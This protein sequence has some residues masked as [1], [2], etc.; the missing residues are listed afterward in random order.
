MAIAAPAAALPV[1]VAF[2]VLVCLADAWLEARVTLTGFLLC[3]PLG[4]AAV[5]RPG[6]VTVVG[7]LA[8]ALA[9]VSGLW[10]DYF[11]SADHIVRMTVVGVGGALAVLAS[12]A[13]E[14]AEVARLEAEAAHREAEAAREQSEAARLEAA[15]LVAERD[16]TRERLDRTL[17]ALAEAVTVHDQRGKTVYANA[18]AARLLGRSVPEILAAEPGELADRFAMTHEDGTPVRLS[19]LPGR[20]LAAGEDATPLLTRS[21][22]KETGQAYWLLTKATATHDSTGELLLVNVIEDVTDAKDAEMRAGFLNTASELLASSLDYEQTLQRVARLAVPRLADWC[23]VEVV[24]DH[25]VGHLVAVAHVDP[26]KVALAYRLRERY[27]TDPDEA[28]GVPA[29]LRSGKPELYPSIS[30]EMLVATARDEEHLE[31]ARALQIRS[32]MVVP[33]KVG[34][35][36]IGAVTFVAAELV[37]AYDENDLAFAEEVARRAATAVENARL[38]TER[39]EIAHMLQQSLLPHQLPEVEGWKTAALYRPGDVSSEVGGDFYD[40]FRT[41]EGVVVVL[42]DVTGKG[43]AAA[44]LTSLARHT[45][46]TAALMG[47]APREVLSLLNRVLREEPD[48]SL[49]TVVCAQFQLTG[50]AARMTSA[51]AGHPLPLRCRSGAPPGPLGVPGVLLGAVDDGDWEQTDHDLPVGDTILFYT[52]GVPDTP[53][54]DGRFDEEGLIA[55]LTGAPTEPECL[56]TAVD[57]ARR[58]FQS[59]TVV[60]DTAMLAIQ[61]VGVA[62]HRDGDGGGSRP[63]AFPRAT[64]P[65]R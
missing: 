29:V 59:G 50:T 36:V 62:G 20:R 54:V 1:A 52:D 13:R 65:P 23:G 24:D 28:T 55:A 11:L 2:L 44:A 22:V 41:R 47:M 33:M 43:V 51:S 26:E 27:P 6:R 40:L 34:D 30:D 49:V 53:G 21:V 7:V 58:D 35:R 61:F 60:D 48:L 17:G 4:L 57:T 37:G 31:I 10:N 3:A 32:V 16:A 39:S 8:F 18:A 5:D 64:D 25:G 46:R 9:L 63:V 14:D 12:R 38:Y 19:E 42:G 15:R 45:A 56:I